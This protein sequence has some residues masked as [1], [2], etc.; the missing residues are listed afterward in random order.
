[1][2]Y[3]PALPDDG[4]N[5]GLSPH[6][7]ATAGSNEASALVEVHQ[8]FLWSRTLAEME[9]LD[10]QAAGDGARADLDEELGLLHEGLARAGQSVAGIEL[11]AR[12]VQGLVTVN[13]RRFMRRFG[14]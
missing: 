1:M 4:P 14:G 13:E 3:L 2:S 6:Q 10:A 5:T 9:R 7:F 11:V 8:H 12:K